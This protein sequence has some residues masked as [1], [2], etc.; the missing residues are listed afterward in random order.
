MPIALHLNGFMKRCFAIA[1]SLPFQATHG[2]TTTTSMLVHSLN[3][4]ATQSDNPALQG[5]CGY[6]IGGVSQG[7]ACSA[8]LGNNRFFV[9]EADEYD[10]ALFDKRSKFV[11][12][13]PHTLICNNLEFDHADIFADLSAIETQFHH[14]IR[15]LASSA[16]IIANHHS[17]ALSRVMSRGCYSDWQWFNHPDGWHIAG[18]DGRSLMHGK[19]PL[20]QLPDSLVGAH[21]RSN[22]LAALLALAH[23][24]VPV[25]ESLSALSSFQGVK[26]RLEFR[27][28]VNGIAL[29]DDFAHHPTAIRETIAA[30]REKLATETGNPFT[31]RLIAVVEPR[32]NSMKMGVFAESLATSL[33]GAD[34]VIGYG[35][36]LGWDL[37]SALAPLA[38]LA[39]GQ[40]FEDINTLVAEVLSCARPGDVVLGMSNGSFDGFY[41]RV[42]EAWRQ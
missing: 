41:E 30:L 36:N 7:L 19:E 12:Y 31:G 42:L 35:K 8:R 6:L 4:L 38:N 22:A 37:R 23:I 40:C 28:L 11:H 25:V 27:G 26:R 16:R 14:L 20:A 9:I 33:Q 32:S 39:G 2:K 18:S 1:M 21:N 15:A 17:P 5:E 10:T 3:V 29:Y 24:Q 13:H 34:W